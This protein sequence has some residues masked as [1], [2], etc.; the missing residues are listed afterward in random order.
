MQMFR[1]ALAGKEKLFGADH[2]STLDTVHNLELLRQHKDKLNGR[3]KPSL[4]FAILNS[5]SQSNTFKRSF[6]KE[7][8]PPSSAYLEDRLIVNDD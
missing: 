5:L 4:L 3:K 6:L 2:M 1:R 8:W 7:P